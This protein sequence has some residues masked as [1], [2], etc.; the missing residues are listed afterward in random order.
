MQGVPSIAVTG[1]TG[2]IASRDPYNSY[3]LVSYT[4][5]T[6]FGAW[7]HLAGVFATDPVI[8]ACGDGSLY[9]VGKDNYNALWSGHYIP[10]SGLQ[11]F[12]LGGGVVQGKPS[13]SCG[14]DNAAY[15][16][17]RDNYNAS[18]V[19]RVA[20]NSWTGWFNG[21]G[22]SA[23][24]TRIAAL[25]GHLG[26]VILDATGAVFR[27]LFAEGSGNG[28]Q[29]WTNVG[30]VFA[31][32]AP[33]G[34]LGELFFGGRTPAGDLYWWRA[35]GNQWTWIGNNGVAAGALSSAPR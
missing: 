5:G 10:G 30:G 21:G 9:L 33:A 27:T 19:A 16:A 17:A 12:V 20:G 6:G 25:G 31:D 7:T 28:W 34:V 22:V 1:T 15:I 32:I 29:A 14:S 8:T 11:G 13:V 26:I 4:P 2:W 24:D 23:I 35:N 18:W 3:W